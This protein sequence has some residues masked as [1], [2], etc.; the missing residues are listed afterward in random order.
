MIRNLEEAAVCDERVK[1]RRDE[2]RL[3]LALQL[4]RHRL[5][6]GTLGKTMPSREEK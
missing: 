6:D 5:G 1:L 2:Q 3:S 4:E